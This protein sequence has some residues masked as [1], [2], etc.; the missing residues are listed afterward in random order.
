MW[1]ELLCSMV[2]DT[3]AFNKGDV[4]EWPDPADAQRMIKRGVAKE[5]KKPETKRA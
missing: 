1:I 2:T 5:A 4:I 3:A